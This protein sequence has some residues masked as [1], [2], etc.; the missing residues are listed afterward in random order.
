MKPTI[1]TYVASG[2]ISIKTSDTTFSDITM[3]N[4]IVIANDSISTYI[5]RSHNL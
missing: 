3:A 2:D 5:T 4:H 1:I